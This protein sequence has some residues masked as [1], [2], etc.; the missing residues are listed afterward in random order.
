MKTIN[1]LQINFYFS[2]ET[3]LRFSMSFWGKKRGVLCFAGEGG[4]H[5][6]L[7]NSHYRVLK[8]LSF[9]LNPHFLRCGKGLLATGM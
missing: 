7:F 1:L 8:N 2:P 9:A 5:L 3:P 6:S 4:Y